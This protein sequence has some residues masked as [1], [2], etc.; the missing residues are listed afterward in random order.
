VAITLLTSQQQEK[1]IRGTT[2]GE[3]KK[4]LAEEKEKKGSRCCNRGVERKN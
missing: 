4:G 1:G 2:L 3:K